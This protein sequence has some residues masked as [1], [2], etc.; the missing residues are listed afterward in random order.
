MFDS[1]IGGLTVVAELQRQMPN[2]RIVYFGD[3]ARFPYGSKSVPTVTDFSR[4]NSSLL[5]KHDVKLIVVAC[6]TASAYALDVLR[7]ELPVPVIGVIE[8]GARAASEATTRMRVGVI[9]TDGTISSGAYQ[10]RIRELDRSISVF[11]KPCPLFVSLA[12]EG[13]TDSAAG[14]LIA[15]EY[16]DPLREEHID[17]LVL[18]CTHYP[19]LKRMIRRVVG[20][21]VRLTDSAEEVAREVSRT[22]DQCGGRSDVIEPVGHRFYVSD[23]P[24]KFREVGERFLGHPLP[25]VEIHTDSA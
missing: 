3:T 18:G 22:L 1:G 24:L 5:L 14:L 23:V 13:W 6:N 16:L 2:E 4:Q 19:L 8:P 10:N 25:T 17:V 9:G 11:A 12:E 20:P 15:H 7:D 21:G